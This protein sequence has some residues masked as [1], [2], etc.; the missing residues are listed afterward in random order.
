M[1][2]N[3]SSTAALTTEPITSSTNSQNVFVSTP[4]CQKMS[5]TPETIVNNP[6]LLA[7][8]IKSHSTT[9]AVGPGKQRRAADEPGPHSWVPVPI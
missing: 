5:G 8:T 6:R 7:Y 1:T 2:L 3:Q 4:V 9:G